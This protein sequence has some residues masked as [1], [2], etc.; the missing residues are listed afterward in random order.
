MIRMYQDRLASYRVYVS[1]WIFRDDDYQD[2]LESI[3]MR[4]VE[5]LKRHDYHHEIVELRLQFESLYQ[6][7]RLKPYLPQ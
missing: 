3:I 1:E 2:Y 5:S 7:L 6:S 4:D